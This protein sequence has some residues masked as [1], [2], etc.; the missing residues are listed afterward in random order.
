MRVIISCPIDS[1]SGYSA[2]SRDFVKSLISQYPNW[3][4]H[5]LQQR[6]GET[7]E[8]YLTDHEEFD[9]QTRLIYSV[10][11]KPDIWIQITVPN[12]FQKVGKYN[13]GMT[14]GIETTICDPSWIEGC[15]RMDLVLT[16]SEFSKNVFTDIKF[17]VKD[18]TTNSTQKVLVLET[19]IKVLFEGVNKEVYFSKVDSK[20]I[21]SFEA[22]SKIPEKFT[23]LTI[24]HWLPGAIGEDRKNIGLTIKLFLE[25][26]KGKHNKPALVVKTSS[27]SSSIIDYG[28]IK[29]QIGELIQSVEGTSLPSI[30]LLHGDI[31]D[32]EINQL[33]NHP[34]VKCMVSLTKGEGFGRPLLEFAAIG[35]PIIVSN[36][37]GHLDFLSPKHTVLVGGKLT[38]VHPSAASPKVLLEEASWFSPDIQEVYNAFQSVFKNYKQYRKKSVEQQTTIDK[39][40]TL[41]KM[42]EIIKEYFDEIEKV[43]PQELEIKLP[44][45][46]KYNKNEKK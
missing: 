46:V 32:S 9:L 4:I 21:S 11:Y 44:P 37:S 15:N 28:I 13:I 40:Y 12:E 3:D 2:R 33:Y 16:S 43:V 19:P 24:G 14:A 20:V 29:S 42:Q 5:I 23:F 30:Y 10:S 25:M 35:K 34:K 1:Y 45:M 17:E 22:L 26:F 41:V 38:R 31:S 6:W 7:P 8:S 18:K 39:K 36:W 27:S